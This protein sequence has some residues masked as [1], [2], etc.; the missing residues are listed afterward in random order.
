MS[1]G[2]F[3]ASDK[4]HA[5]HVTIASSNQYRAVKTRRVARIGKSSG[6]SSGRV[7]MISALL[8][9]PSAKHASSMKIEP[10]VQMC[11]RENRP[12]VFCFERTEDK[13]CRA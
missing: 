7:P 11:R 4:L 8:T 3:S 6:Q 5:S 9:Q 10:L 13:E 1:A 2:N 12:P